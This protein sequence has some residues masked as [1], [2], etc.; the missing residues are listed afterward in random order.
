MVKPGGFYLNE[1]EAVPEQKVDVPV[2]KAPAVHE[3]PVAHSDLSQIAVVKTL[4]PAGGTYRGVLLHTPSAPDQDK[5]FYKE[6]AIVAYMAEKGIKERKDLTSEDH[7]AIMQMPDDFE[8]DVAA[9]DKFLRDNNLPGKLDE[10]IFAFRN[11]VS[12]AQTP[13]AEGSQTVQ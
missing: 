7:A 4:M 9:A 12:G 13:A 6:K 2:A 8:A 11:K 5:L 10:S 3:A 1:G